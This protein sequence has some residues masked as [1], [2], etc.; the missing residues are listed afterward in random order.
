MN[1]F[2]AYRFS[3][4]DQDVLEKTLGAIVSALKDLGTG[5]FCSFWERRFFRDEKFPEDELVGFD[6]KEI[7]K[8][9]EVLVLVDSDEEDAE[10]LSEVEYAVSHGKKLV[11]AVKRGLHPAFL[12]G[13]TG[14]ILEFESLK[15]LCGKLRFLSGKNI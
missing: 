7:D 8:S 6:L 5:V 1:I 9:D 14:N 2:L 4:K 12:K 15:E 11:L 13:L 10:M 3:G